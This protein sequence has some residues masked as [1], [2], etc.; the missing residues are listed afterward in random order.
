MIVSTAFAKER[1]TVVDPD[2]QIRE[3]GGVVI[4]TLGK[5][6]GLVSKKIGGGTLR[7][8]VWSKNKGGWAPKPLAPRVCHWLIIITVKVMLCSVWVSAKIFPVRFPYNPIH[9]LCMH[10]RTL[11]L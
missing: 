3:G 7:V 2:L 5:E 10:V 8:S 6:G 1:L 4:Q 9:F 11:F